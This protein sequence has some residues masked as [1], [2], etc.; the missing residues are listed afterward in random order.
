M[1][2]R[3]CPAGRAPEMRTALIEADASGT[4][5]LSE[6]QMFNAFQRAGAALPKQ[7]VITMCR[8]LPRDGSGAVSAA[9]VLSA[10]Q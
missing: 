4:G 9:A 2:M 8:K 7:L 10:I 5:Y 6:G 3:L 1:N